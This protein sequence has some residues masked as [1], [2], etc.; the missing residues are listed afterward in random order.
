MEIMAESNSGLSVI[1]NILEDFLNKLRTDQKIGAD[2][3]EKLANWETLKN[4]AK[5]TAIL[6]SQAVEK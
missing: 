1:E 3:I 6:K 2:Q 4:H 5:V